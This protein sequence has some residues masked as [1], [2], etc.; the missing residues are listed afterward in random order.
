MIGTLRHWWQPFEGHRHAYLSP[1][2]LD[3]GEQVLAMCGAPLVTYKAPDKPDWLW[4]TCQACNAA[5]LIY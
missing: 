2:K 4:L 3:P 1:A 5:A